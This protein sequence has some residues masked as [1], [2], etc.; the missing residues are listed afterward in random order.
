M[1]KC[2]SINL[3]AGAYSIGGQCLRSTKIAGKLTAF[4]NNRMKYQHNQLKRA[5]HLNGILLAN[6]SAAIDAMSEWTTITVRSDNLLTHQLQLQNCCHYNYCCCNI[7]LTL[8]TCHPR[9]A[10]KVACAERSIHTVNQ[11]LKPNICAGI[12]KTLFSDDD[13]WLNEVNTNHPNGSW[14]TFLQLATFPREK[15]IFVSFH[16]FRIFISN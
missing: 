4:W 13:L 7:Y 2:S 1:T 5:Q 16:S 15:H 11:I 12:I 14:M 9:P 3:R 8:L 6:R 10:I